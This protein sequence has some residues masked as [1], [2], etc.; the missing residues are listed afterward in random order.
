MR[1]SANLT[2]SA[3]DFWFI[4]S[5]EELQRNFPCERGCNVVL[6][7]DVPNY[8][9]NETMP[10]FHQ[11]LVRHGPDCPLHVGPWY[12]LSCMRQPRLGASLASLL[13][14]TQRQSKC[15]ASHPSTAR[16]CPCVS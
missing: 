8:V 7:D 2:C 11:C 13:Q 15:R 6:G 5:C 10:T 4:N 3:S 14:V 12:A 1:R 9:V 16:L